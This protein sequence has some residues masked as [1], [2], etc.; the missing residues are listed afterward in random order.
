MKGESKPSW[1]LLHSMVFTSRIK[2]F[3]WQTSLPERFRFN[4][5][6][7]S[8]VCLLVAASDDGVEVVG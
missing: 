7:I 3:V 5:L 2:E 8:D 4:Y 1:Q 6:F